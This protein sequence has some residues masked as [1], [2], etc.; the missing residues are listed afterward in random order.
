M[1]VRGGKPRQLYIVTS[2]ESRLTMQGKEDPVLLRS[3]ALDLAAS[4]LH[5]AVTVHPDQQPI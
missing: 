3:Q 2:D 4:D 1:T 5:L